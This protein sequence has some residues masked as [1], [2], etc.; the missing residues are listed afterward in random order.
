MPPACYTVT[1]PADPIPL[2]PSMTRSWRALLALVLGLVVFAGAVAPHG[3]TAGHHESPVG[4]NID[5]SARHPSDPAHFEQST[6]EFQPGCPLCVLQLQTGS[7]LR[8]PE[9]LQP[10]LLPGDD[11]QAA[12]QQAAS[13]PSPRLG[14]ARAPPLS[15]SS[16]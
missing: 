8:L 5:H 14:P 1:V 10:P 7:V 11:I 9:A 13:R 3:L 15:A 12:V 6:V 4:T 2:N 16:L